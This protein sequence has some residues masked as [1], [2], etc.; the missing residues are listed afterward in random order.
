MPMITIEKIDYPHKLKEFIDFPHD[1]YAGDPNYVPELFV[2]QRDMLNPKKHP[3]FEHSKLQLFL[4][5]RD[6]KIVGR[7]AAIRN[8]NHNTHSNSNDGFFGFFE[9]INDYTV[10]EKLFD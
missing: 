3:F 6:N 5:Y 9:C 2:A 4:A 7:I 1:L 8:N 10:A